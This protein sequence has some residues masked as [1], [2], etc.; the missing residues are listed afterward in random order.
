MIAPTILTSG[1]LLLNGALVM[2]QSATPPDMAATDG[3]TGGETDMAAGGAMSADSSVPGS[4]DAAMGSGAD[5]QVAATDP[6]TDPS[7]GL[8]QDANGNMV[9]VQVVKVSN[10]DA[11][12]VFDPEEITADAGSLVQF[13][14]YPKVRFAYMRTFLIASS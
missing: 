11:D 3:S 12:L 5:S 1:L 10:K 4:E 6:T 7:Q 9:N 8:T 2:G 13:Q 14:F